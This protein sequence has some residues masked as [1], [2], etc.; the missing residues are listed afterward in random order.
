M[1]SEELGATEFEF[2]IEFPKKIARSESPWV[3]LFNYNKFEESQNDETT[4]CSGSFPQHTSIQTT[5]L[6]M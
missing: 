1:D 4:P 3:K 5:Q 6:S 2:A